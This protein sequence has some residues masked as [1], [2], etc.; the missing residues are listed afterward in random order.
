MIPRSTP[1]INCPVL[2]IG[3]VTGSVAIKTA[4]KSN[5]PDNM[6]NRIN[7]SPISLVIHITELINTTVNT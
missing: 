4:P 1:L 2:V 7:H 5:P 6:L 3:V